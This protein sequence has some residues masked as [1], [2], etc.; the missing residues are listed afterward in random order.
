MPGI[1]KAHHRLEHRDM[2]IHEY[3]SYLKEHP[4]WHSLRA[5]RC[6]EC[7][8]EIIYCSGSIVEP[9][10]KHN[11]TPEG[12]N[13][14]SL[15]QEGTE[16][17]THESLLRKKLFKEEDI[18][19]NF[20]LRM[21]DG[22][23]SS[24]I[25]IPPFKSDEIEENDK[26]NTVLHIA[27]GSRRTIEKP[28]NKEN[29]S[30]GVIKRIGLSGFPSSV[31][32]SITGKSASKNIS[33]CMK[34]FEPCKQ[35]YSTLI[36]QDYLTQ[37]SG[38]INLTKIKTFTCKR[39]SGRIYTGRHYLI[40]DY[41]SYGLGTSFKAEEAVINKIVLPKDNSF[42]YSVYDVVFRKVT[43]NT[44][45]FC[46]ERDC[47]LIEKSDA[48]ILWPP[49]NSIGNYKYFKN[50]RTQMFLAFER[51]DETMDMLIRPTNS[52]FFKV[53]NI[54]ARSFYVM[55]LTN[56]KTKK[57]YAETKEFACLDIKIDPERNYYLFS[58]GVLLKKIESKEHKLKKKESVIAFNN[59]LEF[60]KYTSSLVDGKI[61]DNYLLS[62][63]RYSS[64][65]TDF[66]KKEY[67]FLKDKYSANNLVTSYLDSCLEY[68]RIKDDVKTYLM[69]G[70]L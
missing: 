46:E 35:I 28:I 58:N 53:S 47:E 24:F 62:L 30:S 68:K 38:V 14:C 63:I 44:I 22:R 55:S 54:N 3:E 8:D 23:W 12:H 6:V 59:R 50:N 9:Y 20:E 60:E 29:F 21:I 57:R 25:T 34:G 45:K 39:I 56:I 32:I 5:L 51:D 40:F 31:R 16:S 65:L 61:D 27:D 33:Y 11:P 37:D 26:N 17:K 42:N 64:K 10:F 36:S 41:G 19:L 1:L 2:T 18:S 69:E 4:H 70:R 13:Y 7:G 15:Y 52:I 48:V 43:D 67:E 49:I 66:S